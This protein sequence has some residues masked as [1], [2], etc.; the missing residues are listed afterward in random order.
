EYV[1]LH[2]LRAAGLAPEPATDDEV[3]DLVTASDHRSIA[4]AAEAS[5][6]PVVPLV[7]LMR[8]RLDERDPDAAR[9]L[10]RGLTSQDVLDTALMLCVRDAISQVLDHQARQ[11]T[12]L[13]A[14]AERHRRT[15]RAGRT[16]TQH[17]VPTT[18]GLTAAGWLTGVL[19][20]A[21]NLAG[22]RRQLP[23]QAG[24]AAGTLAAVVQL[25]GD[26]PTALRVVDAFAAEL[27]LEPAAPWHVNRRPVT[28]VGD[29]LVT[30]VD[31]CARI[32]NDVVVG[33]RP[34]IG[35]L[36]EAAP[37]GSSTMP[38]K[39]NPVLAIL[40]RGAAIGAPF[41]AA[42]LHAAAAAAVDERPDG[43][44]HA[45][46]PALRELARTAV[47]VASQT[48]ELLDG[49]E[50]D[51]A[52]MR[53]TAEQAAPRLLA[54]QEAMGGTPAQLESYLGTADEL[55]DRA[56]ERADRFIGGWS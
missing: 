31:A 35:E 27:E 40:V 46:W 19:D 15:V 39:Q 36:H 1:W 7:S 45:E 5:G 43:A 6:N 55:V 10:H 48:A 9:W 33:A 51:T 42:R 8:E 56:V 22:V 47:T 52:R 34:E 49:L 53:A 29:A 21:E 41:A 13:R 3:R 26:P 20:A 44:W 28:R 4:V 18:F 54:E 37:G 2:A 50:V 16:L 23:V 11:V 25:A 38:G 32:A 24:G 30:C 17:A 14:L 12:A